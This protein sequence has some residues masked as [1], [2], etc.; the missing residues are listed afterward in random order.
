MYKVY[1][2]VYVHEYMC[3]FKN[4]NKVKQYKSSIPKL[5]YYMQHKSHKKDNPRFKQRQKRQPYPCY[6][7]IP[8]TL[9]Y[10]NNDKK[11]SYFEAFML[12]I[13]LS[14]RAVELS[15]ISFRFK[16]SSTHFIFSDNSN[17]NPRFRIL[18]QS[19]K[20]NRK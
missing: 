8:F 4:F 20:L 2:L 1:V 14:C 18:V 13:S 9:L 17:T 19:N 15:S 6:N 3:K 12:G 10:T 5:Q 7:I 11:E 16:P